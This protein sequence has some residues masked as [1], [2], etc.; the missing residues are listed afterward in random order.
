MRIGVDRKAGEAVVV[1][2]V[3]LEDDIVRQLPVFRP[4]GD[5]KAMN[6]VV[7]SDAIP[8]DDIV[9]LVD[10]HPM[11]FLQIVRVMVE[12]GVAHLAIRAG[13]VPIIGAADI[14]P[15]KTILKGLGGGMYPL[16][17]GHKTVGFRLYPF[18]R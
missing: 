6:G 7:V 8:H 17:S 4:I 1:G 18:L 10:R 5:V 9:P 2:K 13:D 12:T 14:Q 16:Q 11:S 3:A 15:V